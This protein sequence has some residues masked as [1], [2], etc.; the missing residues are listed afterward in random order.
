MNIFVTGKA[1]FA[2]NMNRGTLPVYYARHWRVEPKDVEAYKRGELVEPVKP[3]VFY[4]LSDDG[5][6]F[7]RRGLRIF[8]TGRFMDLPLQYQGKQ[9][10]GERF[11]TPKYD[12]GYGLIYETTEQGG[13]F[14]LVNFD[15]NSGTNYT[16]TKAG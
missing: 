11:I 13:R 14:L 7:S 8:Y 10:H 2:S 6:I 4:L 16:P 15:Y 9:V 3:I 12:Q 1:R 5:R